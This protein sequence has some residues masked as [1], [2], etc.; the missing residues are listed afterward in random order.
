MTPQAADARL[1]GDALAC[2]EYRPAAFVAADIPAAVAQAECLRAD[3]LLQ[4]IAQIEDSR[5]A[6]DEADRSP[7]ALALARIEARLDLLTALVAQL[8]QR[9]GGDPR[10]PLHWSAQG[11]RLAVDTPLAGD[12]HGWFRLQ[13]CD[14]LP[15]R[16]QLPAQVIA[17]EAGIAWLRFDALPAPLVQT[18]ERHL[19]RVHR[20]EIAERRRPR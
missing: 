19:F 12:T 6:E 9:D 5:G 20:R 14:W 13:P 10:R 8:V 15:E 7:Q 17:C 2:D 18:L 16:L 11:V 1:F 3:A 4:S